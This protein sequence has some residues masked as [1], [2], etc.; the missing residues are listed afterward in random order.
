VKEAE[1]LVRLGRRFGVD[2]PLIAAVAAIGEGKVEP[3]IAIDLLMRR[4]ARSE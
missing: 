2:L 3:A 4:E 1:A